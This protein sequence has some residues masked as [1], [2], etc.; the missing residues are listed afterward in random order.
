MAVMRITIPSGRYSY[1]RPDGALDEVDDGLRG[2]A[3]R[4]DLGHTEL[5]ELRDVLVGDRPPDGHDDVTGIL[6]A[7]QLD[8]LRDERHV[9]TG[10]DREADG[11]GVLLQ[12][13]LHDLLRRL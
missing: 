13:G 10:Q 11:V 4:E 3:G 1:L 9:R 6:L 5:L 2:R 8:D 12:D 7:Q